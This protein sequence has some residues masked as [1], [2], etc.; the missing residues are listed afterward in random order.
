MV[1]FPEYP[2]RIENLL[3]RNPKIY[4]HDLMWW[5][6]RYNHGKNKYAGLH[7]ILSG[8]IKPP[9]EIPDFTE[10]HGEVDPTISEKIWSH[11]SNIFMPK[12]SLMALRKTI[13][14]HHFN[15]PI[16][17]FKNK[18][19]RGAPFEDDYIHDTISPDK[20]IGILLPETQKEMI[21][22]ISEEFKRY[23]KPIYDVK[24]DLIWAPQ[25]EK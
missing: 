23:K 2:K 17:F 20:I 10:L 22:K 3:W 1:L 14:T 16:V 6:D 25:K 9:S 8:G 24:G 12:K 15:G 7:R 4:S 18:E 11:Q 5:S 19:A 21:K 13:K